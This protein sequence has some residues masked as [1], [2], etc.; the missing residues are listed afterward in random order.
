MFLLPLHLGWNITLS[1]NCLEVGI[2]VIYEV[3]LNRTLY[4]KRLQ[5]LLCPS[6]IW[7]H[8]KMAACESGSG[9]GHTLNTSLPPPWS[10]RRVGNTF[11]IQPLLR[12]FLFYQS[13]QITAVPPTSS[14]WCVN[15]IKKI[16][17]A[18]ASYSHCVLNKKTLRHTQLKR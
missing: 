1:V 17:T 12:M 10:T 8:S 11:V 16:S 6:A 5:E 3:S 9:L 7:R 15:H 14:S 2:L 4:K 18:S 13:M